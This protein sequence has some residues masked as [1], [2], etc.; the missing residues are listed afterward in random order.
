MTAFLHLIE[1]D[2]AANRRA[3]VA[4]LATSSR[5]Q[6]IVFA[7]TGDPACSPLDWL[8]GPGCPCCLPA[9]HPRRR[10][11]QAASQKRAVRIII[12]AGPPGVAERIVGLL[13]ALP[14]PLSIHLTCAKQRSGVRTTASAIAPGACCHSS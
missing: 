8:M 10:L 7:E 13:R 14:V 5:R 3:R 1:G 12:D 11:W 9:T 4:Q 6:V 2:S